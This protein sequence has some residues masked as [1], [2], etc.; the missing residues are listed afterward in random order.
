MPEIQWLVD[1]G[2]S[3]ADI[4]VFVVG[5]MFAAFVIWRDR[6][7]AEDCIRRERARDRQLESM[8]ADR[9]IVEAKMHSDYEALLYK[10]HQLD[11]HAI[12]VSTIIKMR[13]GVSTLKGSANSEGDNALNRDV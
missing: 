13:L 9:Q 12:V 2:A 6:Q 7:R 3:P 10:Y 8:K 1:M 11:K 5:V 4:M